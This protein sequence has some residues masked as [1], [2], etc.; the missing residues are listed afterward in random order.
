[1]KNIKL[2]NS[3]I[4]FV[5]EMKANGRTFC[6]ITIGTGKDQ[7]QTCISFY[8]YKQINGTN[9]IAISL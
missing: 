9:S 7:Q 4:E 8:D 1:M 3:Q 2:T 6:S 5:G